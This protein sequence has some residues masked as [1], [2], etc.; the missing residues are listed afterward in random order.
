LPSGNFNRTFRYLEAIEQA[1]G[2]ASR[3]AFY[4]IAGNE[5]NLRRWEQKLIDEWRLVTKNEEDGREY[6]RK[7]EL[8]EHLHK[9]LKS[10]EYVGSLFQELIRDRL[11]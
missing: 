1:Q 8:G 9:L 11:R 10:H 7:T 2:K 6:Y 4:N 3:M 5:E